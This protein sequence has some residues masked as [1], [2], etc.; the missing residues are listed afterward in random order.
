[1]RVWFTYFSNVDETTHQALIAECLNSL[2]GL[3]PSCVFHNPDVKLE[4]WPR[5]SVEIV[6]HPHPYI[7]PWTRSNPSIQRPTK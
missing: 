5:A 1:M 3:F 7:N 6:T 2:L 4:N